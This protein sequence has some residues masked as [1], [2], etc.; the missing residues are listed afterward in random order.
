MTLRAM[1]DKTHPKENHSRE[2]D[3]NDPNESNSHALPDKS[4]P[5]ENNFHA[6][7]DDSSE[8][9]AN[10]P[11]GEIEIYLKSDCM[12][13]R[14]DDCSV[15]EK[16]SGTELVQDDDEFT[17]EESFFQSNP[18][19][20]DVNGQVN[21]T[22]SLIKNQSNKTKDD[23]DSETNTPI[24]FDKS[25]QRRK[26]ESCSSDKL[27]SSVGNVQNDYNCQF[28]FKN[29]N[30]LD[31]NIRKYIPNSNIEFKCP[32]CGKLIETK[33]LNAFNK[34]IDKCL[35]PNLGASVQAR[36]QLPDVSSGN[37]AFQI[38]KDST[39][40][41]TNS[42]EKLASNH[43]KATIMC[44]SD[45]TVVDSKKSFFKSFNEKHM[46]KFYSDS[47][48]VKSL[49]TNLE[50]DI[51]SNVPSD[52]SAST[53]ASTN[54]LQAPSVSNLQ[55]KSFPFKNE[56]DIGKSL[57]LAI[58]KGLEHVIDGLQKHETFASRKPEDKLLCPVCG[59]AHFTCENR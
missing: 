30:G 26:I 50:C 45:K 19:D 51:N 54:D 35:N 4:H 1:F 44:N 14:L 27:D 9:K 42:V 24:H 7:P 29:S 3:A 6:L 43:E 23:A 15:G 46:N 13:P 31:T 28:D 18:E 47:D 34:H 33:Y 52:I 36:K 16:F 41:P 48:S 20:S 38:N 32:V 2:N 10:I 22:R 8:S 55:N 11:A 56:Q 39:T 49:E 5:N 40:V 17:R 21:F 37:N 59:T 58:G 25:I 12:M 57:E 53:S